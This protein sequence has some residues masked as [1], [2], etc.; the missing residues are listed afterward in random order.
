MCGRYDLNDRPNTRDLFG[1]LGVPGD[2]VERFNIAPGGIGQIVYETPQGRVLEDAYWSLLIEP[3]P[4]GNG[5]RPNPKYSTFNA[6]SRRLTSSFLWK[7]RYERQRAVIPASAFYEWT[8][9]KGHKQCHRIEPV[10]GA[11]A[12]GGLYERWHFGDDLVT[13][14]SVITLPPHPRFL[15][16]HDKSIPLMLEERDFDSWLD[17]TFSGTDAF[18]S[19]LAPHLPYDLRVSRVT[20]PLADVG[21]DLEVIGAEE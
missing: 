7:E 11:I 17:H 4:D 13:S 16:I 19:L 3:K 10:D 6:Q 14:F 2:L 5:Y 21:N 12:F 8:G 9:E 1:T 15:H 20:S 18:L